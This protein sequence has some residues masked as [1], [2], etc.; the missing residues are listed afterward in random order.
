[1]E[2]LSLIWPLATLMVD[3]KKLPVP[4]SWRA[5]M[6]AF[7][8]EGSVMIFMVPPMEG[9]ARLTALRPR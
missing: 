2:N 8:T 4:Y 3:F 9:V 6:P 5:V 7:W 1:M